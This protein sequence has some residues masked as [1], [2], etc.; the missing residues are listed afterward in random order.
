MGVE[1]LL[2][3]QSWSLS[4]HGGEEGPEGLYRSLWAQ[5]PLGRGGIYSSRCYKA[6]LAFRKAFFLAAL[7][8]IT[9][10]MVVRVKAL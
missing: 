8:S 4:L 3:P 2:C 6:I 7:A 1:G 9:C 5:P 10:H